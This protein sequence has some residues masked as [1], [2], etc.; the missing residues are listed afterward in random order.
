VHTAAYSSFL[1]V[2][3][4]AREAAGLSQREFAK[5]LGVYHQYVNKCE[6]GERQLNLVELR[7]WCVALD[8]SLVE[9]V[10]AWERA[11]DVPQRAAGRSGSDK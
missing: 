9:F 4:T 11:L 1:E 6:T 3:R 8:V 10:K 2:L 5:R 7:E